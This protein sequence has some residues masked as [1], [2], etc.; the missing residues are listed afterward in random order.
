MAQLARWSSGTGPSFST[1][2]THFVFSLLPAAAGQDTTWLCRLDAK[3]ETCEV[4]KLWSAGM[5]V[6]GGGPAVVSDWK[7]RVATTAL[8]TVS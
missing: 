4:M 3:G 5:W 8:M 2:R 7:P 6:D 1:H